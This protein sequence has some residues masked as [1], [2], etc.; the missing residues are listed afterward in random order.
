MGRCYADSPDIDWLTYFDSGKPTLVGQIVPVF[1]RETR[2]GDLLGSL[3]V[4][5]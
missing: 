2:D 3:V 1:I 4:K 5:N